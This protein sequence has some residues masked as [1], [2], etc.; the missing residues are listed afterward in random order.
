MGKKPTCN[1]IPI[2]NIMKDRSV[3]DED[4]RDSIVLSLLETE[5]RESRVFQFLCLAW[6]MDCNDFSKKLNST[7]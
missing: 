5:T 7:L 6:N 2:C 1:H 3:E 4:E